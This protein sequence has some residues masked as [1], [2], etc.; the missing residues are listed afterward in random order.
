MN[1][2][3]E[4]TMAAPGDAVALAD[5]LAGL[6]AGERLELLAGRFGGGVIASTSFGLQA[7]V[8]LHLLKRHVPE[9]PVVF[10][11]TGYLFA[12]TYQY[13]ETL[14]RLL[15]LDVRVYAPGMTAARTEALHGRL[16]E[17]G[18]EGLERYAI[19]HKIEPMNRALRELGA[20]VWLSGVRR[21]QSS[22][23]SQR[24]FAERQNRTLKVYPILD[25][26]DEQVEQYLDEHRLPHHPLAA[27]GYRTLGDWHST[28]PA[29]NGVRAEESRFD[30]VRYECGLHL[31]SRVGDFQI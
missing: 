13:A 29:I 18:G 26:T 25:W 19:S 16:W 6:T 4:T 1:T 24:P 3:R 11:D 28:R 12:A 27:S 23:R 20:E 21:S 30:G 7:A 31:D 15:G 22:T 8:M 17:Q 2:S 14:T 5:E 10:V 9:V